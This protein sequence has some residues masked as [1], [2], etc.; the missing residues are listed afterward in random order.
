M[1]V[2][3]I[4]PIYNVDKYLTK[5]VRSIID[6]SYKNLEIILVDD[7][8]KDNSSQICDDFAKI[9]NRVKVIHKENAGLVAARKTGLISSTGDYIL[10]IDGDDWV[11]PNY[12]EKMMDVVKKYNVDIVCC[13]SISVFPDC[14]K[15]VMLKPR[16]GMFDKVQLKKEIYPFLIEDTSAAYFAPSAWAKLFKKE[17]LLKYEMQVDDGIVMGEDGAFTKPSVF[18]ANSIYILDDYLYCYNQ[19]NVTSI[20]RGKKVLSWDAPYFIQKSFLH[21]F[22]KDAIVFLDQISRNTVHNLFNVA[23]SQF[24]S[25]E[26]YSVIAQN[27]LMNIT[28]ER[29]KESIR[30]CRYTKSFQGKIAEISLRYKLIWLIY[31]CWRYKSR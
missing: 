17:L 26:K 30:N 5:C 22:G 18:G 28:D 3:I 9:D 8:A 16:C 2:S 1:L 21:S 20:T 14:E 25:K 12:V 13:G 29:Y 10:H 23:I 7:G 27:I 19:L 11:L 15:R 4:V 6:Q 24:N 31:F